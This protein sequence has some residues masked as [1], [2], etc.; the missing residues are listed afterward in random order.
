MSEPLPVE[1]TPGAQAAHSPAVCGAG[2][3]G[4]RIRGERQGPDP[5]APAHVAAGQLIVDHVPLLRS[6]AG[7]PPDMVLTWNAM[8]SPATVDVVVHLHGF[9]ARGRS[10]QLPSRHGPGERP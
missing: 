2:P 5:R 10:M 7:T 3:G 1:P 9:S 4:C 8:E 6:H